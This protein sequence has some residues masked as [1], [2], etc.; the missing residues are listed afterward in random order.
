M[1][2]R[3]KRAIGKEPK[4]HYI[5]EWAEKRGHRQADLV[6]A[7]GGAVDKSTVSRWFAGTLPAKEHLEALRRLFGL[8]EIA[9]LL[10]HPDDDWLAKFF[11]D[12]SDDERFRLR[13]ILEAAFPPQ[14]KAS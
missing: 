12:K 14:A 5:S 7:L 11:K 10:R 13:Q 8:E 2:N 9:S 6:E 3:I 1:V 4:V